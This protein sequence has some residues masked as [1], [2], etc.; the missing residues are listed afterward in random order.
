LIKIIENENL[1]LNTF[2]GQ[3]LIECTKNLKNKR[4]NN[5]VWSSEII[6]FMK[7]LQF[8]SSWKT[9]DFLKGNNDKEEEIVLNKNLIQQ[10]YSKGINSNFNFLLPSKSCVG[11]KKSNIKFG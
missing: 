3:Y 7:C 2:F 9:I 6:N 10:K 11:K 5:N 1:N 4:N 8:Y